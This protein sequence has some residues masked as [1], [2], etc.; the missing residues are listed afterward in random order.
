M[1]HYC[2]TSPCDGVVSLPIHEVA[3]STI[4]PQKEEVVGAVW[5]DEQG[6]WKGDWSR[7]RDS[8]TS[9]VWKLNGALD[10][11]AEEN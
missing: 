2:K 8:R 11:R 3:Q 6:G 7:R 1:P 4:C 10:T 9:V 5:S